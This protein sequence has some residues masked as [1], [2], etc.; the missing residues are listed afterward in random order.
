MALV[1][2]R[3]GS[4]ESIHRYDD[5]SY[6]EAIETTGRIAAGDP[7][8]DDHV[9]TLGSQAVRKKAV[10]NIANPAELNTISGTAGD[11]IVVVQIV[12]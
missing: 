5:G 2:I 7:V 3:I 9:V 8:D 6:D 1:D 4:M 12:P 10:T 11:L